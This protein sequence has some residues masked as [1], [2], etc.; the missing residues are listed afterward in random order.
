MDDDEYKWVEDELDDKP[1]AKEWIESW[2]GK[3][4][5]KNILYNMRSKIKST[6]ILKQL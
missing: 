6:H 1:S 5:R 3:R 4:K 2:T